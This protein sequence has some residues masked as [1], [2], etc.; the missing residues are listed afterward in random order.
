MGRDKR[1]DKGRL[2][3]FVPLLIDTLDTPAWRT[4]SHGAQMLYVSL[5]RRYSHRIHNNGR[6]FVSQRVAAKELNS[7]HNQIARWYRELQH[8][9]FIVQQTGGCL[10]ADG[11]GKAPHWRLTEIGYMRDPPTR[12]FTKWDGRAFKNKITPRQRPQKRPPL[13]IVVPLGNSEPRAGKPAHPVQENP[14]HPRA[15]NPA[16]FTGRPCWKTST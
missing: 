9:G 1:R 7:H 2:E 10:G 13:A 15:G 14:A 4:M 6:L 11:H 8:F 12:D 5:R 16:R 3:P